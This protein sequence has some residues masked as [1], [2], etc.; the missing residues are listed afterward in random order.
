MRN[1][2]V[3]HAW[4]MFVATVAA[5][6][7]A[8]MHA[9]IQNRRARRSMNGERRAAFDAFMG[10][11]THD[12]R[13]PLNV[14]LGWTQILRAS[15]D[16]PRVRQRAIDVMERNARAVTRALGPVWQSAAVDAHDLAQP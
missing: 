4:M 11:L 15:A 10:S 6:Q 8:R 2:R 5:V 9:T 16:D 13:T 1:L 14:L 12:L 7:A 3:G